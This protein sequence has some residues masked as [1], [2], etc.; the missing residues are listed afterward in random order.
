MHIFNSQPHVSNTCHK[1]HSINVNLIWSAHSPKPKEKTIRTK[2]GSNLFILFSDCISKH[3]RSLAWHSAAARIYFWYMASENWKKAPKHRKQYELIR[4]KVEWESCWHVASMPVL[5]LRL[6]LCFDSL[7]L[8][9]WLLSAAVWV[10]VAIWALHHVVK[11]HCAE[12]GQHF[13]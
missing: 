4:I 6:M 13:E 9:I 5:L 8:S 10:C 12:L 1:S 11:V 3:T 2:V 7:S